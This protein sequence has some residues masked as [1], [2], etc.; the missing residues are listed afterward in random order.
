MRL[1]SGED[2]S[3]EKQITV[4]LGRVLSLLKFSRK[5]RIKDEYLNLPKLFANVFLEQISFKE[6]VHRL[7]DDDLP[8][9]NEYLSDSVKPELG[10]TGVNL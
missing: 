1:A 3:K 6:S 2:V 8:S 5:Q 7:N 10:R 9:C 4:Y